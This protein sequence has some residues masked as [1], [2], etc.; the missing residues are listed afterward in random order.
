MKITLN[1]TKYEVL[2]LI[3]FLPSGGDVTDIHNSGHYRTHCRRNA[4]WKC[5]DD[6]NNFITK[7]PNSLIAN[8]IMYGRK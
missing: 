2:G 5:F 7:T 4:E 8:C 3:E 1:N 6:R